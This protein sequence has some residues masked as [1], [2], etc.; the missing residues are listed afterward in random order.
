MSDK[1]IIENLATHY[2]KGEDLKKIDWNYED[3]N[4]NNLL[5]LIFTNKQHYKEEIGNDFLKT[6]LNKNLITKEEINLL[7]DNSNP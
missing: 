5:H 2:T 6:L 4:G 3:K 7:L 1:K